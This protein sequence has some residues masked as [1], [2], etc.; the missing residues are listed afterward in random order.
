MRVRKFLTLPLTGTVSNNNAYFIYLIGAFPMLTANPAILA[1][2]TKPQF[3]PEIVALRKQWESEH[4]RKGSAEDARRNT[5]SALAERLRDRQSHVN[6]IEA[7]RRHA[8]QWDAHNEEHLN[9]ARQSRDDAKQALAD[10]DNEVVTAGPL[11]ARITLRPCVS[12]FVPTVEQFFKSLSPL[13]RFKFDWPDLALEMKEDEELPAFHDRTCGEAESTM[14]QIADTENAPLPVNDALAKFRGEVKAKA[15]DGLIGIG[16]LFRAY[17]RDGGRHFA[18]AGR[19]DWPEIP[20]S[21]I[22]TDGEVTAPDGVSLVAAMFEE[23]LLAYGE[24][25]IKA[26]AKAFTLPP[27]PLSERLPRIRALQDELLGLHRLIERAQAE[28][29]AKKIGFEAFPYPLHPLAQLRA[30]PAAKAK[31]RD[32]EDT[33]L[34]KKFADQPRG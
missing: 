22:G 23:Q 3:A 30:A 15:R 16:T 10:F 11:R 5:R 2:I 21:R 14:T 33:S 19:V 27:V 9:E 26:K 13:D 29:I 8:I 1:L 12:E 25:L 18:Q 17:P 7:Q 4:L 6:G 28:M 20:V 24:G 32:P 34:I 31:P